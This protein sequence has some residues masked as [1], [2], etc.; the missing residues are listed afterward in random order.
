MRL[1]V[2]CVLSAATFLFAS[3]V[4]ADETVWNP[5][6]FTPFCSTCG[7]QSP[8]TLEQA[9]GVELLFGA[10]VLG[11]VVPIT[12]PPIGD[13]DFTTP[14]ESIG[15]Q[16]APTL[17]VLPITSASTSSGSAGQNAQGNS[18]DQGED[19]QGG[20]GNNGGA[21]DQGSGLEVG[22]DANQNVVTFTTNDV[23]TNGVTTDVLS[24][25]S[26]GGAGGGGGQTLVPEPTTLVLFGTGLALVSTRLRRR[27]AAGR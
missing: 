10:Q 2:A 17:H 23:N 13:N 25:T 16:G 12:P 18:D 11:P 14:P 24:D 8:L 1:K 3:P 5:F 27:R 20:N 22:F 19:G 6:L 21:G 9:D 4:R 15:R 7:P 26:D